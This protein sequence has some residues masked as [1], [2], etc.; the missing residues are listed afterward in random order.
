MANNSIRNKL[1]LQHYIVNT[2][3]TTKLGL[4]QTDTGSVLTTPDTPLILNVNKLK[5]V[6]GLN[7]V[8]DVA[9]QILDNKS[10]IVQERDDR[11]SAISSL[12]TDLGTETSARTSAISSLTTDLG[13]EAS[14]RQ[15]ADTGLQNNIDAIN[16]RID[17]ILG[18]EADG[19]N[20]VVDTFKEV[21]DAYNSIDTS[22]R[23]LLESRFEKLGDE[24]DSYD[25]GTNGTFLSRIGA[26]ETT[27]SSGGA[28]E[29]RVKAL[30]DILA[31]AFPT[32]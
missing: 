20:T 22:V 4:E 30:E 32:A 11:T 14:A 26:L 13:T 5:I 19:T 25:A 6:D 17:V 3:V 7:V 10:G 1:Q 2:G 27:T 28:L 29:G 8:D 24:F 16:S 9:Q 31:E 12:T 23:D 21:I 15:V 18:F